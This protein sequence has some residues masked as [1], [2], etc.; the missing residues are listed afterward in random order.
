[1]GVAYGCVPEPNFFGRSRQHLGQGLTGWAYGLGSVLVV[2]EV[3][4]CLEGFGQRPVPKRVLILDADELADCIQVGPVG[5]QLSVMQADICFSEGI[6]LIGPACRPSAE[7]S[8][9]E[10]RYSQ[11]DRVA[12]CFQVEGEGAIGSNG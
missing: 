1:M 5:I 12:G 2:I 7:F 10:G 8:P 11:N 9:G 3:H 4:G 6:G